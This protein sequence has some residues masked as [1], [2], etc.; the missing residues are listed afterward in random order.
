[1]AVSS[2]SAGYCNA[3]SS[4]GVLFLGFFLTMAISP[5]H[6]SFCHYGILELGTSSSPGTVQ[7]IVNHAMLPLLVWRAHDRC[8]YLYKCHLKCYLH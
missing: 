3:W 2:I 7:K 6:D 5:N 8:V 4:L 1:M